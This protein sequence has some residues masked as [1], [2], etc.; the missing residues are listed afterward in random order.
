MNAVDG[1]SHFLGKLILWA[2]GIGIFIATGLVFFL[3]VA[4][5]RAASE[6]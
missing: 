1:V 5:G 4:V 6:Y 2:S 3:L